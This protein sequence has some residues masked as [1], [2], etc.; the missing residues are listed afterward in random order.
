[1]PNPT[2]WQEVMADGFEQF[3]PK[4]Q[5]AEVIDRPEH[6]PKDQ[7][8]TEN[9]D[10]S[11]TLAQELMPK[12][13]VAT[14]DSKM[15]IFQ[16]GT[17]EMTPKPVVVIDQNL[18][19]DEYNKMRE[20]VPTQQENGQMVNEEIA[21]KYGMQFFNM[22]P[23]A[24][25]QVIEYETE[26]IIAAQYGMEPDRSTAGSLAQG[27][28][29]GFE[30]NFSGSLGTIVE[31]YT[32]V[33]GRLFA[34]NPVTNKR[35]FYQDYD[36]LIP[37]FD[38]MNFDDRRE[39]IVAWK[40][41]WYNKNA[42]E[43]NADRESTAATV[44]T[45]GGFLADPTT[46]IP[47]GQTY[48]V[49]SFST[50][51]LAASDM[52]LFDMAQ[53]GV[54]EPTRIATAAAAGLVGGP[55]LLWFGRSISSLMKQRKVNKVLNKYEQEYTRAFARGESRDFA[56]LAARVRVGNVDQST[57]DAMY[58][59]TGRAKMLP[60]TPQAAKVAL[61]ERMSFFSRSERLQTLGNKIENVVTPISDVVMRISPRIGQGLR[62]MELNV[63]LRQHNWSNEVQPFFKQLRKFSKADRT[64]LKRLISTTDPAN[65][66]KAYKLIEGYERKAGKKFAGMTDNFDKM[67]EVIREVGINYKQ[68][69]YN[70]E[71]LPHYFPRVATNP[72]ALKKVPYSF[73]Q[74]A[75]KAER[76]SLGRELK[77]HEVERVFN[78]LITNKVSPNAKVKTSG[79]LRSREVDT[80]M[81]S[82]LPHY[83]DPEAAVHSYIRMAAL[84]IER[85]GF[86]KHFGS[87]GEFLTSGNDIGNHIGTIMQKES[88]RINLSYKEQDRL[89]ELLQ[90]RFT[91]GEASPSEFI[92]GFKNLGYTTT[93]GNPFAALTQLGDQAFGLYKNGIVNHLRGI[94]PQRISEGRHVRKAELGLVD[95]M[96]E[97][98]ANPSALKKALDWSLKYGG[99]NAMDT[100]GKQAILNG[101]L[102]KSQK[103]LRTD[104]GRR[105][106]V[107]KWGRYFENETASLM[108]DIEKYGKVQKIKVKKGKRA[109]EEVERMAD[110]TDNMRLM[111]W[112][113]LSDVQPIA[114]SEMP[115]FYLDHPN[116]RVFYMLKTFTIK[117]VD[118]MRREVARKFAEGKYYEGGKN[119]AYF[120][121]LWVLANGSA[122]YFK[123]ALV[124][125]PFDMS[126]NAVD[127]I[128]QMM[129]W[130]RYSEAKFQ[131]EG[132]GEAIKDFF[133]PPTP[134]LDKPTQALVREDPYLALEPIPI[135]GKFI[136]KRHK[137][138][139]ARAEAL[140]SGQRRTYRKPNAEESLAERFVKEQM[141]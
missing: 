117:Q 52:F 123:A 85:A 118:F 114:L 102:I 124:G 79:S 136:A 1:M 80:L 75:L 113:E 71:M 31:A 17:S 14:P 21:T 134:F 140:K 87:K 101:A 57:L 67:R 115:K 128:M 46:L 92:R 88:K 104:K 84:D 60:D 74:N 137:E 19:Q 98:Y 122:D 116:G 35:E 76:Q 100:F 99:F 132:A 39:A 5:A 37:G 82:M 25:R 55:A 127:N 22:S 53:K 121:S 62:K 48:K 119:L 120:T 3:G 50:G 91:T 95:A 47:I 43:R 96:E 78:Y 8:I 107:A 11:T 65:W 69:G 105:A 109:G 49:A 138:Q 4:Q 63:H 111:L 30:K 32:G 9:D 33:G 42:A 131:R 40:E 16:S 66:N 7:K 36:E 64:E 18:N 125:E 139:K 51:A 77:P 15:D 10:L 126:D 129:L 94:L 81:E 59:N 135:V 72:S 24:R 86:L 61:E 23:E 20:T 45:V 90:S 68:A 108:A 26:E 41:E 27:F 58:T 133:A 106:F 110:L 103:M 6:L 28:Q 2:I 97:I 73:V 38:E 44:G 12:Q 13:G 130:S 54:I 83:A 70:F 89:V 112:H 56:E 29:E 34:K 141:K 93:L